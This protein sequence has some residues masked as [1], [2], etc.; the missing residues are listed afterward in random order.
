MSHAQGH[1]VFG[2]QLP[3]S[4]LHEGVAN[5]GK[6]ISSCKSWQLP[7]DLHKIQPCRSQ[8]MAAGIR[9]ARAMINVLKEEVTQGGGCL[10]GLHGVT[11]PVSI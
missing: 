10:L 3:V 5:Q 4:S 11:L 6:G 8:R 2:A 7:H 9:L 1:Q